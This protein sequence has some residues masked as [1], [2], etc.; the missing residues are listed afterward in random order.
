[1][2]RE[3]ELAHPPMVFGWALFLAISPVFMLYAYING[4]QVEDTISIL[5]LVCVEAIVFLLWE[6]FVLVLNLILDGWIRD[7]QG[8]AG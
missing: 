3:E 5:L 4:A 6:F 2:D 8:T 7:E 1:M